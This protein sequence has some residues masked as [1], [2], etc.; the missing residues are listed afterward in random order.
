MNIDAPQNHEITELRRLW[1]EAFGDTDT[2]LDTFFAEA[3]SPCR[4][5][6]ARYNERVVGALYWFNCEYNGKPIAYIYAVATLKEYRGRG[7]CRALMST[8]HKRL[9]ASGYSGAILVP[10]EKSLFNFYGRMGYVALASIRNLTS[11]AA[12][13]VEPVKHIEKT[14]YAKLRRR[15]LPKNSVIQEAE[16]LD[17]LSTQM[18]FYKGTDFVMAACVEGDT[19][20]CAEILGNTEKTAQI[21]SYFNCATGHFRTTGGNTPFAMYYTIDNGAPPE[22]FGL[23]F[24]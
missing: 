20:L 8:L 4:A 17:F 19:L 16:G 12:K 7:V 21:V 22:Y 13:P 9:K 5:L 2:F 10:S 1:Q 18:Q 15:Y 3:F 11:E 6:C 24:D 14:E 23:A